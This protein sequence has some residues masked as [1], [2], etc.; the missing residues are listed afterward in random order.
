MDIAKINELID[1][2]KLF[3]WNIEMAQLLM[4][5]QS[6]NWNRIAIILKENSKYLNNQL[7]L[8]IQ[9]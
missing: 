1:D 2:R 4:S 8:N 5:N 3:E 9:L 6:S 7:F